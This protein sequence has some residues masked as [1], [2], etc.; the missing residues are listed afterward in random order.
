[1]RRAVD[2]QI[3][4]T[5]AVESLTLVDKKRNGFKARRANLAKKC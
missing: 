4:N 5:S 1:M 2:S 3:K